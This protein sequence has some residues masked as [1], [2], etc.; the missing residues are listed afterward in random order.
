MPPGQP[1]DA[2][3]AGLW[4]SVVA[5]G[6]LWLGFGLAGLVPSLRRDPVARWALA[7]PA[8]VALALVLMLAHVATRGAVF[9]SPT[10]VRLVVVLLGAAL[11]VRGAV[12][13]RRGSRTGSAD[14]GALA[15]AVG[16]SL[17]ATAVW[18]PPVFRLLPIAPPTDIGFHTGWAE[19]L[20]NG[21]S[22]PTAPLTG[23]V[24]NYYPWLFH[25]LLALVTRL[26]PGG[27]AHLALAP[28][29]LL[30]VAG[31][32]AA[33]FAVG[34]LF[35]G[36]WVGVATALL[37]AAAG[38]WGY[39]LIRDLDLV[40]NPRMGGG[41]A[42]TTYAGDLLY[43]RPYNVSFLNIAPSFP[44]DVAL[45]LLVAVLFVLA[46]AGRSSR[47]RDYVLSG[48]LL[49]L[50]GLTQ[51]DAFLVGILAVGVLAALA[52]RGER[53]RIAGAVLAP[54]LALFSLWLVPLAVSYVRLG[55]FVNTTVVEPVVLPAWAI[56]G[57]WGILVPLGALGALRALRLRD[58]PVVRVIAAVLV[59]AAATLAV[60][61]LVPL[62][63]GEG[64]ETLGRHHRYW[65]LFCL[66]VALLAGIGAHAVV[67][68]VGRRSRPA[69]WVTG[70]AV[71]A[72]AL[73]SP[74]IAS[75]ALPR[76]VPVPPAK[77]EAVRAGGENLLT[78]L[79]EYGD[80]VCAVAAPATGA[81]FSYTGFRLVSY[82]IPERRENPARIRWKSIYD[83]IGTAGE[84]RRD[85]LLLTTGAAGEPAFRRIVNRYGLDVVVVP[86]EWG[87]ADAFRGLPRRVAR[88][89]AQT[90]VLVG[91][92]EC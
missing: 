4:A 8:V 71:A 44:R 37:G 9:A 12:R 52:P 62:V 43:V 68:R 45:A 73:P 46:R 11:A 53:L 65:P 22:T 3:A 35:R 7:F 82:G 16:S 26:T 61:A 24:P 41:E 42:A 31:A 84:R 39:V 67:T 29:Q 27:N 33:L 77:T 23:D 89:G 83:R 1:A 63:A 34:Y 86:A 90:Y 50:V 15:F 14:R 70:F 6:F 72:L 51:S 5:L 69:A 81:V 76:V 17:L 91:I 28:V 25:A 38:G 30:Q 79:A 21:Q 87:D 59:A 56:L 60:S 47:P 55:G 58:D 88:L 92:D 20:L 32:A 74:V 10:A 48:L 85:Q 75:L 19:Q 36:R 40:R 80:G 57:S 54:A 2:L 18:A 49:G 66:P 64:F 78:A 13:W